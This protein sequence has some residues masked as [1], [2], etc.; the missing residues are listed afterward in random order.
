MAV[1]RVTV[2]GSSRAAEGE[3]GYQEALRLGRLLAGA[4]Y[5]VYS[6]G[7]GG[8][9]EAVSRGAADA[10]GMVVGITV[11]PWAPR[12]QANSWVGEEVVTP[13]LFERLLRLTESD[14]FVALPGGP[15]TLGEMALVWN[16][17]QTESAPIRPLILVGAQ[18]R[19]LVRCFEAEL[20]VEARDL[21]LLQFA[22]TVDEVLPLLLGHST[23]AASTSE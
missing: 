9:M 5:A 18:W 1:A 21:E 22:A 10:G 16:L 23:G 12:L 13:H 7:Y 15:G 2:F 4:G 3:H 14:A 8:A 20:R 11:Q 17:F 19:R 6:G